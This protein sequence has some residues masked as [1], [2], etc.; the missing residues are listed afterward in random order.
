MISSSYRDAQ[1]ALKRYVSSF[2]TP[3]IVIP[4]TVSQKGPAFASRNIINSKALKNC[5]D[6]FGNVSTCSIPLGYD[7]FDCANKKGI[8][9]A[10]WISA[11]G[12]SHSVFRIL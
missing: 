3:D 10:G 4:H 11:A 2:G 12:M 8:H 5:F 9:I 6:Q 7:Y 1:D